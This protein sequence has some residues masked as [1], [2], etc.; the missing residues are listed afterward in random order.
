MSSFDNLMRLQGLKNVSG[1]R[2]V[3]PGQEEEFIEDP[4]PET[5]IPA[6]ANQEVI[7][8]SSPEEMP[9]EQTYDVRANKIIAPPKE[10]ALSKL[11]RELG[12]QS[13]TDMA[14]EL[15]TPQTP[16]VETQ[17]VDLE[18]GLP[19]VSASQ[20]EA[21]KQEM[22]QEQSVLS[23]LGNYITKPA[24]DLFSRVKE[25]FKPGSS[26]Q[27]QESLN[28]IPSITDFYNPF[29]TT[30]E[31]QQQQID[32][33]ALDEAQKNPMKTVVYGATNEFSKHPEYKIKFKEFTGLDFNDEMKL[34]T[35]KY[36]KALYNIENGITPK[37]EDEMKLEQTLISNPG[38]QDKFYVGLALLMPL[39][40]GGVFGKEAG[41]GA[42]AGSAEG[43]ANIYEKRSQEKANR[44]KGKEDLLG[45]NFAEIRD[46]DTN[47]VIGEGP[48]VLPNFVINPNY[49]N[50]P[51]KRKEMGKKA[52]ELSE[53]KAVFD[54]ANESMADIIKA[55]MQLKNPDLFAKM[56]S[57]GLTGSKGDFYKAFTKADAPSIMVDG[58]KVNSAVYLDAKI[59]QLKDAYRRNEQMKNLTQ[60]V[61]DHIG[62]MISNPRTTGLNYEDLITQVLNLR[63]R[64]QKILTNRI[65]SQGFYKEPIIKRFKEENDE[66]F[67]LLN[68]KEEEKISN[69]L[70]KE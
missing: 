47:K 35:E 43:I 27:I 7:P 39:I 32:Q 21:I 69:K 14:Q 19:P 51:E 67:S 2:R 18:E 10:N 55:G 37:T 13:N 68:T 26:E 57:I 53:E 62:S 63:D 6:I 9:I 8:P 60:S 46:M 40:I 30:E 12:I 31:K 11:G 42:L 44:L 33:N 45:M 22:P 56:L 1:R 23:K 59:E 41:L 66:L 5:N 54:V 61:G 49:G 17:Q 25:N 28:K 20:E 29:S 34:N 48:E 65:A 58:R 70:L 64:G 24:K 36:E 3:M 15:I 4:I 16:P 38:D 50:T 52:S